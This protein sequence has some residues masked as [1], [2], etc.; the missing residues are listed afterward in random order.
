MQVSVNCSDRQRQLEATAR[1]AIEQRLERKLT[2]VEW[3]AMRAKLL[4]FAAI[5]RGWEQ[6]TTIGPLKGKVEG[7][8]Q[9]ER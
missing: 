1:T 9:R 4:E 8:C 2:E 6:A 3:A 5:L 7:L